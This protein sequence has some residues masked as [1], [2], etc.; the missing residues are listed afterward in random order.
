M[1]FLLQSDGRLRGLTDWLKDGFGLLDS[2]EFHASVNVLVRG[3]A[4]LQ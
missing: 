3:E 4:I 2:D 1:W